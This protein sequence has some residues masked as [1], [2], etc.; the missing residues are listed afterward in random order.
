MITGAAERLVGTSGDLVVS[1]R[2][3]VGGAEAHPLAAPRN[4]P[5]SRGRPACPVCKTCVPAGKSQVP[6][7]RWV[8][9]V[10]FAAHQPEPGSASRK[11]DG[12]VAAP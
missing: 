9:R 4:P 8:R 7:A 11:S 12:T 3:N 2:P 6:G 1:L 5:A 10:V